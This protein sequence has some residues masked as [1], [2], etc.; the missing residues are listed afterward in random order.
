MNVIVTERAQEFIAQEGG[1][2]T[3]RIEQR[4]IPG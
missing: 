1:I 2:I 4:L 3:V